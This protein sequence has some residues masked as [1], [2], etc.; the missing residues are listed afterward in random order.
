MSSDS[1]AFS[2]GSG[3]QDSIEREQ[4]DRPTYYLTM[5]SNTELS[6][7]ERAR[8]AQILEAAVEVLAER[9]YGGASLSAIAERVGVSKGVISY[10]FT[11]KDDLLRAVVASVLVDAEEFMGPRIAAASSHLEALTAYVQSNLE[12]L[13]VHRRRILALI[14]VVNGTPPASDRPPPYGPGHR[15]AVAV[16]TRMLERG[17]QAGEFGGFDA[18]L[19]AVAMRAAI[20]ACSELL[21]DDPDAD[22]VAYGAE[23]LRIFELAVRR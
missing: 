1:H 15:N 7:T 20:D 19:V 12:F 23:L 13:D 22:V 6:F 14:E 4:F 9:G 3:L 16:L 21:R 5:R 2:A 11:A 8:R 17:Q 18:R 10:Y